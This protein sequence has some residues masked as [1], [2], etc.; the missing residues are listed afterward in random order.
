MTAWPLCLF[1][2]HSEQKLTHQCSLSR[3]TDLV[4]ELGL[5]FKGQITKRCVMLASLLL[6]ESNADLYTSD[7]CYLMLL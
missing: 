3:R 2:A 5:V 1:E 7:L 6:R 4:L